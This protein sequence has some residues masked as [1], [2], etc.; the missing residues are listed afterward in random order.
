M[1]QAV[2]QADLDQAAEDLIMMITMKAMEVEAT[3]AQPQSL[4]MVQDT[5]DKG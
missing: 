4:S 1:D 3:L 5:E 2:A